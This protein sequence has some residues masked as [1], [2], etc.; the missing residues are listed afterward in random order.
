MGD[1]VTEYATRMEQHSEASTT[2]DR[3]SRR[4]A[5]S[6]KKKRETEKGY[7]WKSSMP[8]PCACLLPRPKYALLSALPWRCMRVVSRSSHCVLA[9]GFVRHLERRLLRLTVSELCSRR[10]PSVADVPDRFAIARTRGCVARRSQKVL[11]RPAIRC[12]SSLFRTTGPQIDSPRPRACEA[13]LGFQVQQP[14]VGR[15]FDSFPRAPHLQL[16]N[17]CI[18]MYQDKQSN[19]P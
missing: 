19:R 12:E 18:D 3:C 17:I 6:K 5:I 15:L 1:A 2:S 10:S 16:S 4:V 14:T 8:T 11:G 13:G 9:L 7:H